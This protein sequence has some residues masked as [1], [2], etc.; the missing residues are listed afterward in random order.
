MPR[1]AMSRWRAGES[2]VWNSSF[3]TSPTHLNWPGNTLVR[4]LDE[5]TLTG[6][7]AAMLEDAVARTASHRRSPRSPPVDVCSQSPARRHLQVHPD[8]RRQR[9]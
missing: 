9:G 5:A 4:A 8:Q 2:D 3:L 1:G 6:P 7:I